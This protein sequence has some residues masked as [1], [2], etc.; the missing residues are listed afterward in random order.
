MAT[1]KTAL[2]KY[3]TQIFKVASNVAACEFN[4]CW[5]KVEDG[6]TVLFDPS[7][8]HVY[9]PEYR[10]CGL[11]EESIAEYLRNMGLPAPSKYITSETPKDDK[12]LKEILKNVIE[13]PQELPDDVNIHFVELVKEGAPVLPSTDTI[14]FAKLY[15]ADPEA[16][17]ILM[18]KLRV[19]S[20]ASTKSVKS[21]STTSDQAPRSTRRRTRKTP[22]STESTTEVS[23]ST[24]EP[25]DNPEST[26]TSDQAPRSTRRRTR[27][28]PESTESTTEVSEPTPE[29]VDN[30]EPSDPV[31]E[32]VDNSEPP[33]EPT[34]ETVEEPK[35]TTRPRVRRSK[36][37]RTSRRI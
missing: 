11:S 35:S 24:T 4:N 30:S 32:P 21:E 18:D 20:K 16:L 31:E 22:E 17:G 10:L 7:F 5:I 37:D 26:T 29:P 15:N 3:T 8:D 14:K 34:P 33:S 13:D 6:S 2:I 19:S 28:T 25:V 36:L 9:A 23:E 1:T 27:K 12:K